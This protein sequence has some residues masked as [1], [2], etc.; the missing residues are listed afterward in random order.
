MRLILTTLV[1]LSAV[2]FFANASTLYDAARERSIPLQVSYPINS[3]SCTANT[4]CPVAFLSAG[5]GVAHTDYQFIARTF[6]QAGF[7]VVAIGHEL[8]TD[9][10][11]STTGNLYLTRA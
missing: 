7:L 1:L 3:T 11:L 6:N 5:Y 4:K 9:P 2:S 8:D 10:P